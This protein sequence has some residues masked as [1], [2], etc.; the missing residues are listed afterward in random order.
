MIATAGTSTMM[1]SGGQRRGDALG[2]RAPADLLANSFAAGLELVR[3]GDH[4]EHDLE[5]AAHRGA[6]QRAELDA[7]DVRPRQAQPDAA[8]AEE[9]IGLAIVKPGTGLSPPASKVR[10]VT[11]R[12][13]AQ[14]QHRVD[15]R[16]T[17]SPRRASRPLRRTGI[18]CASA[19]CRRHIAASACSR[20]VDALDID[21]QPDP[22]A[23]PVAAGRRRMR[24]RR[25]PALA[26]DVAAPLE[27]SDLLGAGIELQRRALA[28]EQRRRP[29][30]GSDP[31]CTTIGMPRARASIAT[32]LVGL[33]RSSA[34]PPPP[35]QSIS[36]KRDGGR[37]SAQTIAPRGMFRAWLRLAA[38]DAQHAI[39]QIGKVGRARLE[40]FVG[41]GL[42]VGDLLRRAPI[43]RQRPPARPRRSRRRPDRES[44]RPRA[45]A[46]WNSR[47]CAASPPAA[48][49]SFGDLPRSQRSIALR[50]R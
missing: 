50:E 34:R 20:S 23:A 16:D 46:T 7:E 29:A 35:D 36:R 8:H 6:R 21:Q 14:S 11:G 15:R 25:G 47:I 4:R 43:A 39:P 27:R 3:Q 2:L 40:I 44:P 31:S 41:R 45:S 48:A 18:R 26:M 24:A 9:R 38:Q 10:I 12:W 22:L 1:P 37:S 32:W 49:A 42:V 30:S 33:P 13:P 5:I 17:A 28:V 19:R